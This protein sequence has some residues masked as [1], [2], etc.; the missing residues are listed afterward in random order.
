[1]FRMLFMIVAKASLLPMKWRWLK[2][3]EKHR[4]ALSD[5]D[6]VV[7]MS[8]PRAFGTLFVTL[9]ETRRFFA[10]QKIVFIY[11]LE[12]EGHNPLLGSTIPDATVIAVPRR[13]WDTKFM[14]SQLSLPPNDW[15]DPMGYFLTE[16]WIERHGKTGAQVLNAFKLWRR[17]PVSDTARAVLPRVVNEPV[18]KRLSP[19]K[20]H[21]KIKTAY[22]AGELDVLNELHLYG[23]WNTIRQSVDVAPMALPDGSKRAIM[24]ALSSARGG[25]PAKL[26]GFHTRYGGQTDK[27]H[28]DGSPLEFYIPAI[29]NL[30]AAGYQVMIQGDR[31][32]HPRF[33]ETFEGMVVDQAM[34]GVD[35]N[36]YRLFC[37]CYSDIFV[38][39]WPVA[40]QLAASN[41]IPALIVNAWPV[42]WGINGT[43]VYY[44]GVRGAD[45]TP[46][47][48][49]RVLEQGALMNCNTRPH[50]FKEL[51]GHDADLFEEISR[52]DQIVMREN[53]ITEAVSMFLEDLESGAAETKSQS[54]LRQLLPDWTPIGMASNCRLNRAWVERY[55]RSM[56]E[57]T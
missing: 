22:A 3:L 31:G 29:R 15:H 40:P 25:R 6:A 56:Q 12:K 9:D 48:P 16:K 35:K 52:C 43:Q 18:D 5:A 39:D 37:G 50:G 30:V 4:S 54:D 20:E 49:K 55:D 24:D 19:F 46:W 23:G 2:Y 32:F 47:S 11:H 33:N 34:L 36:T 38:G 1:M 21:S 45:G 51:F 42:G 17:M 14:G 53:E 28:R 7:V 13:R 57:N 41:N 44:R 27:T 26:C 8:S 10:G